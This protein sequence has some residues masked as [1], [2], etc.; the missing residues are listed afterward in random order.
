[1]THLQPMIIYYS[2]LYS[3]SISMGGSLFLFLDLLISWLKR[4]AVVR[5]NIAGITSFTSNDLLTVT[6]AWAVDWAIVES[7]SFVSAPLWPPIC[8]ILRELLTVRA[9]AREAAPLSVIPQSPIQS[10][11]SC[12]FCLRASAMWLIPSSPRSFHPVSNFSR[13]LFW[14][15]ALER[16]SAPLAVMPQR[17]RIKVLSVAVS[18]TARMLQCLQ[19]D[20]V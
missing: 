8:N 20:Y 3:P 4:R 10:S 11:F 19:F 5:P 15:S 9:L 14:A 2:I 17:Y 7:P 1:M 13:E 16:S 18:L 6:N 12:L